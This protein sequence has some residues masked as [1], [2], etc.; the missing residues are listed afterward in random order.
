MQEVAS[1]R[2]QDYDPN[3][4][5]YYWDEAGWVGSVGLGSP[6]LWMGNV[7][8]SGQDGDLTHVEFWTTSNNAGYELHVY[9][10]SFGTQLAY[11]TGTCDELGY[12]SIL[13]SIP[14]PLTNGQQFSVA[15]EMT[16][17]RAIASPCQWSCKT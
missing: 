3:E 10:G 11:Q 1:Y 6:T 12:Y 16:T 9:D 14:V 13:L 7:F 8:D 17:A 5:L 15:V 4:D 2:Y